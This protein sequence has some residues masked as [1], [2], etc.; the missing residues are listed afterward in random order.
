[1]NTPEARA[2]AR[3]RANRRLRRITVG[4]TALGIAATGLLGMTAAFANDGSSTTPG[5]VAL[6]VPGKTGTSSGSSTA[7]T[8]TSGASSASTAPSVR[9]TARTAHA[10]TGGS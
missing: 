4:T 5:A 6:V 10:S 7:T 8:A 9:G 3:N 1:M 2:D